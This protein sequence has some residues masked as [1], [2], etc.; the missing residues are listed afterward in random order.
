MKQTQYRTNG[1]STEH[2]AS[3]TR[4]IR[5]DLPPSPG[6]RWLLSGDAYGELVTSHP[7]LGARTY[8]LEATGGTL[9]GLTGGQ[10]EL[11]LAIACRRRAAAEFTSPI[12]LMFR[13]ESISRPE[14]FRCLA[15]GDVHIDSKSGITVMRIHDLSWVVDENRVDVRILTFSATLDRQLWQK[16][17]GTIRAPWLTRDGAE[18]YL[19]TEWMGD[20]ATTPAA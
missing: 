19:H 20:A 9:T 4:G 1:Y 15:K 18:M 13:S 10:F 2:R 6:D 12:G 3:I 17:G 8:E 14:T 5:G 16:F 7:I 11:A